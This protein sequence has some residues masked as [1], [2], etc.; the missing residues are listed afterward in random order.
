[1]RCKA[2]AGVLAV[3]ALSI[4]AAPAVAAS[5]AQACAD[6]G[7]TYQKTGSTAQCVFPVG[8]SDNTKVTDQKG[9]FNSSHDEGYT[10]PNGNRPP[11]QQGGD[12]LP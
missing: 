7:G 4:T 9:S 8:N 10:N 5:G 3:G 12:T 2:L 1:M 6:A 11:G